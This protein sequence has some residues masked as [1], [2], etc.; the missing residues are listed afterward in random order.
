MSTPTYRPGISVK[1]RA[2]LPSSGDPSD[3]G[4]WF[5]AGLARKGPTAAPKAIRNLSEFVRHYGGRVTWSI[6]YDSVETFFAEGGST[7]YIMRVVGPGATQASLTLNSVSGTVTTAQLAVDAIGLGPSEVTVEVIAGTAVTTNRVLIIREFG[8]EVE[9]SYELATP[10]D[11]V[12]WSQ[13]SDFVRVRAVGT[14][15]PDVTAAAPLGSAVD[16]RA[17][18]TDTE[19]TAALSRFSRD[20]GAGQVSFPGATTST[21]YDALLTHAAAYNRVG[22][23]DSPDTAVVSTLTAAADGVRAIATRDE[24]EQGGMF[25]PWPVVPG[26]V[27]GTTRTVPPSAA[28]AGLIARNDGAGLSPNAPSAG[29]ENGVLRFAVNVSQPSFTDAERQDLNENGVNIIRAI[30]EG[31]TLYGYRSL[32]DADS[33]WISFGA[34]R[35][36]MAVTAAAYAV[37]SGFIFQQL[38]GRGL[39]IGEFVGALTGMLTEFWRAGALYGEDASEAFRVE[40][41]PQVNTPTTLAANELH[42]VLAIRT[43]PFSEF[44]EIEIVKVPITESV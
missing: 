8:V 31:I 3:T 16:D 26:V 14:G 41:G 28:V 40:G 33:A 17:N 10:L 43:S 2:S 6:L 20:L 25:A 36:R 44:V 4:V 22:I 27:R 34:A 12:V 37:A 21:M 38:D 24:F 15:L 5:A 42:A 19:R 13:G 30:P 23:L 32:A 29:P 35:V 7:V 39:K 18:I 9:R 11:A 1:S